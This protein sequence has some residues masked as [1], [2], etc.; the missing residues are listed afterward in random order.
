MTW[1][2]AATLLLLSGDVEVNPL[3]YNRTYQTEVRTGPA[4]LHGPVPLLLS[5]DVEVNP[6]PKKGAPKEPAGPTPEQKISELET[7]VTEYQEKIT[8]KKIFKE[9][10]NTSACKKQFLSYFLFTWLGIAPA[11]LQ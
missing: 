7:K 11:L 8:G 4:K 6:G 5:G 9:A 3:V 2:L 1:S 10:M